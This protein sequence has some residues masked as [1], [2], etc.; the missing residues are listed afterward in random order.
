M[1]RFSTVQETVTRELREDIVSG[2]L[3]PGVRLVVEELA[4]KFEVSP[5][6]VREAIRQL[7][8][9][10]LVVINSY[11]GATV[12][13]LS[14]DEIREIFLMR[15]LLEGTAAGLGARRLGPADRAHLRMLMS[16][17]RGSIH[18]P[19][20][21]IALDHAFHMTVYEASGY[22][23]LVHLVR[24]LRHDIERY[25]RLYITLK[26]NIPRSMQRHR[27]I[28]AACLR[29]DGSEARRAT[30]VHLQET[31]EMFI[32]ELDRTHVRQNRVVNLRP[33]S[34]GSRGLESGR[35]C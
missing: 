32:S 28:L 6:P 18:E 16:K 31:A 26:H 35:R 14:I 7:G 3:Q 22:G 34:S 24:Q 19:S 10:A 33:G 29:G 20:R 17:M 21:W 30:V 23:R 25:I 27:Q 2:R 8:A 11:R 4:A 1:P 9:E 12:A 15:E 5:M 13:E